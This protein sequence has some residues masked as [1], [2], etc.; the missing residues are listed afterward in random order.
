MKQTQHKQRKATQRSVIVWTQE[1]QQVQEAHRTSQIQDVVEQFLAAQDIR[2]RSKET[3]RKALKQFTAY[4]VANNIRTPR[5]EDIL[6]YKQSLTGLYTACSISSYLTAVKA[7]F[8]WLDSEG[9]YPNVAAGVKGA[10]HQQGFRKDAL[11]VDQAR[12]ILGTIDRSTLEGKRDHALV[13]LLIHTGL[14]TVEAARADIG[15]LRQ[16][17]GEALLNIQGKGRDEKDAFV[18]VTDGVLAAIRAYVKARGKIPENAPLFASA[19]DRNPGGRLTTRSISRIVKD[20]MRA[21]GID[22]ERL[23]AHSL[24]HSAVTFSLLGGASI[25]EAQHMARH[26]NVN[27]TM[28]YAHNIDRIAKAAERRIDSLLGGV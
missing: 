25:Q 4:L 22:S 1:A 28:I 21:A 11:T 9:K 18:V 23:T 10:K 16:E 19:S 14:R 20:A 27:T 12:R 15:D 13:S 26:A 6:A 2:P 3:Y 7:L 8:T 24:R 5:R 17:G